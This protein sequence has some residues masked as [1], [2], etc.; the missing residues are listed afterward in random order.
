VAAV[1]SEAEAAAARSMDFTG[2][3]LAPGGT[4]DRAGME[5]ASLDLLAMMDSLGISEGPRWPSV[6][7]IPLGIYRPVPRS[8]WGAP[9]ALPAAN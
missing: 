8:I 1:V 5:R 3:N 6:S 7:V 4:I 9:A 2:L